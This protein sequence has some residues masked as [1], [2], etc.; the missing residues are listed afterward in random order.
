M[1]S[2]K[3]RRYQFRSNRLNQALKY[4]ISLRAE[5]KISGWWRRLSAS[6]VDA[7]LGGEMIRKSGRCVA[8]ARSATGDCT[9]LQASR[10]NSEEGTSSVICCDDLVGRRWLRLVGHVEQN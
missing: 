7:V 4:L 2:A 1:P 6:Q 10:S 5:T 3:C 8:N 9:R